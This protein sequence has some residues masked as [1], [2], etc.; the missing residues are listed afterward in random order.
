MSQFTDMSS[1]FIKSINNTQQSYLKIQNYYIELNNKF[2]I[3]SKEISKINLKLNSLDNTIMANNLE[4][5]SNSEEIQLLKK[6][7]QDLTLTLP[8]E[9][10]TNLHVNIQD[11]LNNDQELTSLGGG[12]FDL[13][14]EF[15]KNIDKL[16]TEDGINFEEES[17]ACNLDSVDNDINTLEENL[18]NNLET[19]NNDVLTNLEVDDSDVQDINTLFKNVPVSVISDVEVVDTKKK[20]KGKGKLSL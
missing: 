13:Y 10:N 20:K 2:Q 4:R 14:E 1:Y 3:L 8:N 6:K 5:N 18:D 17:T 19:E 9:F 12:G 11:I 16:Y 15:Q 7:V